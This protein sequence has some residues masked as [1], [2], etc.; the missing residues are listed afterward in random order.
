MTKDI[1]E[2]L[3]A[4]AEAAEAHRD[5]EPPY[6]R[7]VRRLRRDP[8]QVYSLRIPVDRLA[9]LRQV[10]DADGVEPSALL[11]RWVLDRLDAGKARRGDA[12]GAELLRGELDT[13]R[14]LLD[15]APRPKNACSAT[16]AP[17]PPSLLRLTPPIKYGLRDKDRSQGSAMV[18]PS[19]E[20]CRLP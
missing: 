18:R 13:A 15:E 10:V 11:R 9:E 17:D 1:G 4:E 6:V 7:H 16:P 5:A 19:A 14:R 8:L 3:A 12:S 2:L 20:R